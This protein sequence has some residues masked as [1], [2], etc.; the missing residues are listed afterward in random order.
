MLP[1][2]PSEELAERRARSRFIAP[3]SPLALPSRIICR[4]EKLTLS[5][6]VLKGQMAREGVA[7][8]AATAAVLLCV[9]AIGRG[10]SQNSVQLVDV[11]VSS[12]AF[13]SY[14]GGSQNLRAAPSEPARLRGVRVAQGQALRQQGVQALAESP[15]CD[16]VVITGS[17]CATTVVAGGGAAALQFGAAPFGTAYG[18]PVGYNTYQAPT[19]WSG[20]HVVSGGQPEWAAEDAAQHAL[21]LANWRIK[22]LQAKL[23]QAKLAAKVM[24]VAAP[25]ASMAGAT[26]PGLKSDSRTQSELKAMQKGL[27]SLAASTSDAIEALSHKIGRSRAPKAR[28]HRSYLAKLRQLK[29]STDSQLAAILDKINR[30]AGH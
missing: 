22:L 28:R 15:D 18:A 27:V 23:E 14:Y 13:P 6:G 12:S 11:A 26:A 25:G 3:P 9:A 19:L 21:N 29:Q 7:A 30:I 17:P 24:N 8:L 5:V 16:T 4:C 10:S 1:R 2:R 20:D